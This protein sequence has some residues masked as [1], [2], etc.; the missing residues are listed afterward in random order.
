MGINSTSHNTV[1]ADDK[2]ETKCSLQSVWQYCERTASVW[3]IAPYLVFINPCLQGLQSVVD[4]NRPWEWGNVT[5]SSTQ[6]AV[7]LIL[8]QTLPSSYFLI[9]HLPFVRFWGK[10]QLKKDHRMLKKIPVKKYI[11]KTLCFPRQTN[12]DKTMSKCQHINSSSVPIRK[13][14][15]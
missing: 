14:R 3:L 11:L 15:I 12:C 6:L 1:S 13:F 8:P 7:T 4:K 10:F 9:F 2:S 5:A